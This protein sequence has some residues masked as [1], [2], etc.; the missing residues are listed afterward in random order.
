VAAGTPQY[1]L[2]DRTTLLSSQP[3][4]G[5]TLCASWESPFH[6]VNALTL[7]HALSVLEFWAEEW[8][9]LTREPPRPM[10]PLPPPRT[11]AERELHS[12][13][14]DELSHYNFTV[15][16]DQTIFAIFSDLWVDDC[17]WAMTPEVLD[18]PVG[19]IHCLM[20]RAAIQIRDE[21]P[22]G[23]LQMVGSTARG[24]RFRNFRAKL[25]AIGAALGF[26]QSQ[27]SVD[28]FNEPLTALVRL[29]NC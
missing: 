26:R 6:M 24:R 7:R 3:A 17:S 8:E 22:A 11:M 10:T 18:R 23:P 13:I 16:S 21:D 1:L 2:E 19:L 4:P 5:E 12:Q 28:G 20:Q 15:L 14:Y 27:T 29:K 9:Q 25:L